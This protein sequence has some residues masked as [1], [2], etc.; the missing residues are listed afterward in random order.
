MSPAVLSELRSAALVAGLM[1]AILAGVELWRRRGGLDPELSRKA[2]HMGTG[3]VVCLFPWLFQSPVTVGLLSAGFLGL[4]LFLRSRKLLSAVGDVERTSVG[5]LLFPLSVGLLFWAGHARPAFYLASLLVLVLP[6][7]AAALVG[8]SYGR[9]LYEV[10]LEERKSLEGSLM[11]FLLTF[12]AVFLPLLL[13]TDLPKAPLAL[14]V[15]QMAF[16][17]ACLEA[18]CVGGVDNLVIPLASYYM[19]IQTTQGDLAWISAQLGIQAL[20]FLVTLLL[21]WSGRILSVSGFL[22]AQAYLYGVFA[23]GDF[24][25]L[26]APLTVYVVFALFRSP[27]SRRLRPKG[28]KAVSFFWAV[29]TPLALVVANNFLIVFGPR[30]L[31]TVLVPVLAPFFAA[32]HG[33]GLACVGQIYRP[34]FARKFSRGLRPAVWPVV[35]GLS[36]LILAAA[37]LYDREAAL[38]L[39]LSAFIGLSAPLL[40]RALSPARAAAESAGARNMALAIALSV[41][42]ALGL[43]WALPA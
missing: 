25:W 10:E 13:M 38:P 32:A 6:D 23:Y 12:L 9:V 36:G 21:A 5:E 14:E 20:L 17:V 41:A 31:Q 39:L 22:A 33:A 24:S 42:L 19:L 18:I 3:A 40:Q 34:R 2:I 37:A 35:G 30:A 16:L 11:F 8:K 26:I 7:A 43:R 15:L 4:L 1:A 27:R 29:S 28:F